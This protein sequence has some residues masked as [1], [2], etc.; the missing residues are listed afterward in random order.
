MSHT[1][2][3]G[4]GSNL[5]GPEENC[6]GAMEKI[7]GH[8][9]IQV[10]SRS[11]LYR[12][13]PVGPVEQGWFVNAAVKI[14]TPLGPLELL[15]TLLSIEVKMGRIRK[16]KWGPRLIDL[17]LLLYDTLVQDEA[18]LSLPHPE[19][20]KRRFVLAPLNEIAE[21]EIHPVLGK[22]IKELLAELSDDSEVIRLP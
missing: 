18:G 6:A 10:L 4:I 11:P 9:E 20:H 2:Y 22:S 13:E 17:D 1:A 8:P 16:E 19:I 12:T 3:I 21:D 5:N 7:A 15:D 14:Q